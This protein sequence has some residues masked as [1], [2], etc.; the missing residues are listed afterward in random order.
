[1]PGVPA[2]YVLGDCR[3]QAAVRAVPAPAQRPNSVSAAVFS[4]RAD[5]RNKRIV[6]RRKA[7]MRT[8]AETSAYGSWTYRL[9]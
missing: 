2:C 7:V 5:W 8:A 9:L 1:V 3:I 4:R 6:V